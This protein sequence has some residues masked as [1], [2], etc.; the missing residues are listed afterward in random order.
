MIQGTRASQL[1]TRGTPEHE[2]ELTPVAVVAPLRNTIYMAGLP[3][4]LGRQ[5]RFTEDGDPVEGRDTK[6]E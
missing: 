5:T 4:G 3:T 1:G 6:L 2:E